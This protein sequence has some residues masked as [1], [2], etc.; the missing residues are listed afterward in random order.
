MTRVNPDLLA[1][2]ARL[3]TKYDAREWAALSSLLDDDAKRGQLRSLIEDL[4]AVSRKRSR[5]GSRKK[6]TKPSPSRKPSR[7]ARLRNGLA[8]LRRTDERHAVLLEDIW[9]K[10]RE[11]ELLPTLGAVR[12]FAAAAGLKGLE[13]TRR[14][15]AV[16]ELMERLIELPS[17]SLEERMRMT[18][19]SQRDL[20]QEYGDWVRLILSSSGR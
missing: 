10:L 9:L 20:G 12:A 6:R 15:D 4:A 3:A 11:R 7:V 19:A 14:E 18:V 17:S 1:D 5:P 16:T 13:S 8:D 2:L